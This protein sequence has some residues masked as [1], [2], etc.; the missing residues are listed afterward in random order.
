MKYK[1]KFLACIVSIIISLLGVSVASES[2]TSELPHRDFALSE[3]E[4][5]WISEH[6]VIRVG[7][8]PSFAPIEY[9]LNGQHKGFT[10]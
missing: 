5:L 7:I 1:I 3:S 4:K 10:D 8:D 2:T 9:S 6:P